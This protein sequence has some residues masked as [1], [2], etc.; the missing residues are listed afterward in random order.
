MHFYIFYLDGKLWVG[1]SAM[2]WTNCKHQFLM[3]MDRF[4]Q[5]L[6][7]EPS[8]IFVLLAV[9]AAVYVLAR[10][11]LGGFSRDN[12]YKEMTLLAR[13][14]HGE[15][16]ETDKLY[17]KSRKLFRRIY[18]S[19]AVFLLITLPYSYEYILKGIELYWPVISSYWYVF[20]LLYILYVAVQGVNAK[21]NIKLISREIEKYRENNK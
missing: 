4:I 21:L 17:L 20:I 8:N 15:I 6:K 7:N 1:C 18:N 13:L 19:L 11:V 14:K 16:S 3:D 9:I 10:K 12:W 2:D 5:T